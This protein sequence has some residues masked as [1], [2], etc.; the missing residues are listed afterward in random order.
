MM[1]RPIPKAIALAAALAIAT[2]AP[3]LSHAQSAPPTTVHGL[4]GGAVTFGGQKLATLQYSNGYSVDV[5]TGGLVDLYGGIEVRPASGPF[6]IQATVGYHFDMAGASNGDVTFSRVPFELI[7]MFDVAPRFR[8]GGGVRYATNVS[9]SSS[10]AASGIGAQDFD[11]AWGGILQGEW[12]ITPRLGLT[13]RY[14]NESYGYSYTYVN[15]NSQLTTGHAHV[16]GSHGGIGMNW[17]F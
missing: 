13:L 16:D 11:D 6:A 15:P 9:L 10:G 12:L 5:T 1:P 7:G 3:T 2:L 17:Y 14:V 8:I 4:L